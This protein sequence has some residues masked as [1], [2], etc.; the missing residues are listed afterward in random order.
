MSK[1][2]IYKPAK[3]AM[4][5][6]EARSKHWV[7][8]FEPEAAKRP[9]ALMGWVSSSDTQRQVRLEFDTLDEAVAYATREGLAY[10]VIEPKPRTPVHK[11]YA[12]NFKFGRTRSWT[13]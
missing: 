1:A 5:S 10:S 3:S 11:S 8:E 7:L 9:E 12:D 4:Q 6:G 13:H 2:R